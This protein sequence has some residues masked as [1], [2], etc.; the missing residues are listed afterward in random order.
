MRGVW[1]GGR[2]CLRD[3]RRGCVDEDTESRKTQKVEFTSLHLQSVTVTVT[4]SL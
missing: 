3:K 4:C 1:C 2:L